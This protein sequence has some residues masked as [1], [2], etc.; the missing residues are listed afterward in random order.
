MDEAKR[1]DEVKAE[2]ELQRPQE[3][4]EDLEPDTHEGDEVK[5]GLTYQKLDIKST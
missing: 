1:P 4:V 2:P 3:M 5:G